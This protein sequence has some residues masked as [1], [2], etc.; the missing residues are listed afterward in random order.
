MKSNF[1][2]FVKKES[3]HIL[4]DV[5]TMMIVILIPIVLMVLF[6][7]AISTEVNNIKVAVVAPH[8][9]DMIREAVTRLERNEYFT[10][11]G[12]LCYRRIKAAEEL[13]RSTLLR[14]AREAATAFSRSCAAE[15]RGNLNVYQTLLAFGGAALEGNLFSS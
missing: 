14:N 7:F 2:A 13:L 10:F 11:C 9:T 15:E 12:Y 1:S 4:R 3:L 8:R 5:R 6:G